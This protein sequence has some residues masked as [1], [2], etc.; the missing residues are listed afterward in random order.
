MDAG[1]VM[2]LHMQ[3]ALHKVQHCC[4]LCITLIPVHMFISGVFPMPH[5]KVF[6]L[7]GILQHTL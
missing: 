7:L 2:L 3:T 5:R 4:H 6:I 1:D